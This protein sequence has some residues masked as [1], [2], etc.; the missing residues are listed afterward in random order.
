MKAYA[1]KKPTNKD[2]F[3][4][5]N[6]WKTKRMEIRQRDNHMCQVCI[7][8]LYDYGS[9]QYNHENI[10]VHHIDSLEVNFD[11]RLDN[12][13]LITICSHHHEMAEIGTITRDEL[14]AI[15]SEQEYPPC[16]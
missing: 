3:R 14:L 10:Q 15:V 11:K 9:R 1:N 4:W 2:R 7:R 6:A 13:N 5:T 12:S 8:K 16:Q